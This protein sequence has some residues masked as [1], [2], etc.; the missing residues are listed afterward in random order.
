ME[1][2]P[3]QRANAPVVD[4]A[5]YTLQSLALAV[6]S[7]LLI[8][9]YGIALAVLPVPA[10]LATAKHNARAG[11]VVAVAAAVPVAVLAA[12]PDLGAMVVIVTLS[13][14]VGQALLT[15]SGVRA[16]RLLLLCV[17]VF[18]GLGLGSIALAFATKAITLA[19][20][21]RTSA[22][23][24]LE[25]ARYAGTSTKQAAQA[26]R[27]FQQLYV[28]VL[29][30]GIASM[31]MG[32]GLLCF[33]LSQL[34]LRR[35][36]LP[37]APIPPFREWQLPWYMAWG[38]LIGLAATVGYGFFDGGQGRVALYVG[39]NLLVVFGSIYMVQGLAVAYWYFERFKLVGPIK[40]IFT[41]LAIFAQLLFLVLTWVGLFDTWFN[42]RKLKREE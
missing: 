38:F 24:Q 41:A 12:S 34:S 11:V 4:I 6:A 30:G 16:S 26:A 7:L 33:L 9:F 19:E 2:N 17:G 40:A 37:N 22:A 39:L 21:N 23:L 13:L 18:V 1:D 8:P 10:L 28:Y 29:P 25:L 42:Y 35:S 31:S 3:R 27:E 15:R 14:G 32:C 5:R 36:G 20:L